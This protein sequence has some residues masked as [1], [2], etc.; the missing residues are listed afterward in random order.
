MPASAYL[1]PGGL[2]GLVLLGGP[3][4]DQGDLCGFRVGCGGLGG[5]SG[6]SGGTGCGRAIP[7][8]M[9]AG[10]LGTAVVVLVWGLPVLVGP[11]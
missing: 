11:W 6:A 5:F 9:E 1:R 3:A 8:L 7:R 4:L 10:L 2:G